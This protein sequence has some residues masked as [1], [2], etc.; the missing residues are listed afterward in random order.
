MSEPDPLWWRFYRSKVVGAIG[1]GL[2]LAFLFGWPSLHHG[3]SL[4][5]RLLRWGWLI[6]VGLWLAVIGGL[7][8]QHH[9]RDS[10]AA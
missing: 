3:S 7:W 1:I 2:F 9:R 4:L 8:W 6:A 5:D 10:P